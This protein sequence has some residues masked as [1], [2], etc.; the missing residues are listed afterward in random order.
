MVPLVVVVEALVGL[1]AVA[2]VTRAGCSVMSAASGES[3]LH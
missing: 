3:C 1:V 2:A